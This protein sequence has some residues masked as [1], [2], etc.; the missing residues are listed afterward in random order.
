M[1][2]FYAGGCP[3]DKYIEL[4]LPILHSLGI[5]LIT[6]G[7]LNTYDMGTIDKFVELSFEGTMLNELRSILKLPDKLEY[8]PTSPTFSS[9]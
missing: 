2:V 7:R 1:L 4:L 9:P 5:S 3:R 6:F 8:Y